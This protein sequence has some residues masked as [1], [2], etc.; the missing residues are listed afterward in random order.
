[1]YRMHLNGPTII[2]NPF[3]HTSK[4]VIWR[5]VLEETSLTSMLFLPTDLLSS[6]CIVS[7]DL[8]SF[9]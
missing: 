1:M 4:C 6:N 3:H 2:C 7:N 9:N 5:V 8:S